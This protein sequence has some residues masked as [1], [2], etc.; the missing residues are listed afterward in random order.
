[1]GEQSVNLPMNF[2]FLQALLSITA[3]DQSVIQKHQWD[4][5]VYSRA[6]HSFS[7]IYPPWMVISLGKLS[8]LPWTFVL[9]MPIPPT[10][11]I[12]TDLAVLEVMLFRTVKP[13]AQSVEIVK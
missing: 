5:L 8:G 7:I 3:T 13:V 9:D 11:I 10:D 6:A 12:F 1:M 2:L 4:L